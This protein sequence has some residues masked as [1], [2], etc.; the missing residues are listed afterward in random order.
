MSLINHAVVQP[1]KSGDVVRHYHHTSLF[2]DFLVVYAHSN[3]GLDVKKKGVL[4]GLS[5]RFV[6]L[7]PNQ[8]PSI[9]NSKTKNFFLKIFNLFEKMV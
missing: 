9:G 7:S 5:A 8:D 6:E 4:Y 3:G 2:D 1:F